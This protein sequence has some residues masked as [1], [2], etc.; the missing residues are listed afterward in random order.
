[1]TELVHSG[2]VDRLDSSSSAGTFGI[3]A[4][5][6]RSLGKPSGGRQFPVSET[7]NLFPSS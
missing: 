1:M 6:H 3:Q 7:G 5:E 2:A 4:G